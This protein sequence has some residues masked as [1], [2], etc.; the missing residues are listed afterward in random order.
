MNNINYPI[1]RNSKAARKDYTGQKIGYI[2]VLKYIER[3]EDGKEIR[4]YE[5]YCN[6]CGLKKIIP[7]NT[8]RI[9]KSHATSEGKIPS[10]GCQKSKGV[11]LWNAANKKDLTGKTFGSLYVIG[12]DKIVDVGSSKKK[13]Q[14]WKCR[15][16]CGSIIYVTTGDLIS[17]NTKS[18]GCVLSQAE[19]EIANILTINHIS[20]L[21]EYSYPDLTT[22]KGN[23]L[24]FDFAIMDKNNC[25]ICLIEYQGEQHYRNFGWFGHLQ[26]EETDEKKKKYC[27]NKHIKLFEIPYTHNISEDMDN[28]LRYIQDNTVPSVA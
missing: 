15:C 24:R 1:N 3:Y 10:C 11:K 9:A 2:E 18:C 21:R 20:F 12:P 23:P 16:V 4:E 26:R 14:S 27:K 8:L 22:N 25:V 17:G 7:H 13:R 28:I 6:A 19:S 5:C